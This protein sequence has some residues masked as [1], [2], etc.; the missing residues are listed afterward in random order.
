MLVLLVSRAVVVT[1]SIV[2]EHGT[3]RVLES[4]K[5]LSSPR[6]RVLRAGRALG[7]TSQDLVRGD[8]L[9]IHAGNRLGCDATLVEAHSLQLDESMLTGESVPVAKATLDGVHTLGD[10]LNVAALMATS[11]TKSRSCRSTSLCMPARP[12]ASSGPYDEPSALC[13]P[14]NDRG[15]DA[16]CSAPPAQ[17]RTCPT[18]AYGSYLGF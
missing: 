7:I 18:K 4:L 13:F 16:D 14:G 12:S 15:R 11:A 9:L 2:Q 10:R 3:E 6:S 17:I 1:I 5:E 8:R